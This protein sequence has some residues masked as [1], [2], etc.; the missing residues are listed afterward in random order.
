[1]QGKTI[2]ME[3]LMR[4]QELTP[5]VG[6]QKVNARGDELGQG[7]RIVRKR[8]DIMKDYY[9]GHPESKPTPRV[10]VPQPTNFTSNNQSTKNK[11]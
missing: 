7:G 10:D 1:M 3:K 2:D 11:G 4:Q 5:A 8:E 6:N 9:E